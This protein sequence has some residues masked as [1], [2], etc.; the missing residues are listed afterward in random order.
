M[1][2]SPQ[3]QKY[4]RQ[5]LSN[6]PTSCSLQDAYFEITYTAQLEAD[7][8]NVDNAEIMYEFAGT[9]SAIYEQDTNTLLLRFPGCFTKNNPLPLSNH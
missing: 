3:K 5:L 8:I 9:L 6:K 4:Q 2:T 1:S 7:V